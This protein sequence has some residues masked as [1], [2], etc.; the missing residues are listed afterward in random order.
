MYALLPIAGVRVP[1]LVQVTPSGDPSAGDDRARARQA[2]P[3]G[4][5]LARTGR[6][7]AAARRRRA[8]LVAQ[9]PRPR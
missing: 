7:V 9:V 4:E 5:A 1:T 3:V 6:P 2:E 8:P